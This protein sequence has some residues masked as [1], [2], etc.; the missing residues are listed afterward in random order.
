MKMVMVTG[1]VILCAGLIGHMAYLEVAEDRRHEFVVPDHGPHTSTGEDQPDLTRSA[2]TQINTI[3]ATG[4][5]AFTIPRTS[6]T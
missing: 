4:Y 2:I 6:T 3:T 1:G 5:A